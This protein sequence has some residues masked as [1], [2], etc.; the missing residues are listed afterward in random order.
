MSLPIVG[1]HVMLDARP[2]SARSHAH[3]F[4][5]PL[6]PGGDVGSDTPVDVLG[7]YLAPVDVETDERP[8][9][10]TGLLLFQQRF[11]A[12]EVSLVEVDESADPQLER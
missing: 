6:H 9:R 3:R 5:D 11:L 1:A 10:S 4:G 2:T 12:D 8:W 7:H